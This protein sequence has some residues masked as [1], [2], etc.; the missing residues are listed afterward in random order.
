[1]NALQTESAESETGGCA[2]GH[3]EGDRRRSGLEGDE[4]R[5]IGHRI[6][7]RG[8][9]APVVVIKVEVAGGD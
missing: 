4:G 3:V 8:G 6:R 5:E 2:G 1:M 7:V 9:V